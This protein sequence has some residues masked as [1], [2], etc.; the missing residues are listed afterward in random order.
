MHRPQ[1]NWFTTVVVVVALSAAAA[2]SNVRIATA[3]EWTCP[4]NPY[5]HSPSSCAKHAV[6]SHHH[7]RRRRA[8]VCANPYVVMS[9][10]RCFTR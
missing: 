6:R 7:A 9:N 4:P 8:A 5:L 3:A 10:H 2:F 1:S